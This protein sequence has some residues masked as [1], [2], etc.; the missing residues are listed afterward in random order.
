MTGLRPPRSTWE[1]WFRCDRPVVLPRVRLVAFPPAGAA[2][3]FF[4]P[5][6]R[7][8]PQGVELL[9]VQYPG[10]E[11]RLLEPHPPDL[12]ALADTIAAALGGRAGVP[13][14]LFGHSL[15]AAIAYEVAHRLQVQATARVVHVYLS[16]RPAP[17]ATG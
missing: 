16:G 13:L 1:R 10:R 2:A 3:S 7:F 5:W 11:D 15:G 14:A 4:R 8:L 17:I 9:G 12:H 6:T